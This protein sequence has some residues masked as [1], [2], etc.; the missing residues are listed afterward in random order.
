MGR[1]VPTS[2][3]KASAEK[4]C[5]AIS[6][7]KGVEAEPLERSSGTKPRWTVSVVCE[8]ENWRNLAEKL[9][10]THL[11][12]YCSMITGIHWPEGP[13]EKKLSLIHI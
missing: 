7:M 6:K 4:L 1:V 5:N 11:V 12:D 13:D 8:P 10:K 2:T 9:S 3:Q